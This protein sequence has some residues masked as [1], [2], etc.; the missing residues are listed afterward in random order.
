MHTSPLA[1]LWMLYTLLNIV[2]IQSQPRYMWWMRSVTPLMFCIICFIFFIVAPH[3]STR[4]LGLSKEKFN[5]TFFYRMYT[6]Y[7][8]ASNVSVPTFFHRN[9]YKKKISINILITFVGKIITKFHEIKKKLQ[10]K[11]Y[12]PHFLI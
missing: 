3:V 10:K 2:I 11:I 7:I 5:K 1:V 4:K 8:A 6:H 9:V 12:N